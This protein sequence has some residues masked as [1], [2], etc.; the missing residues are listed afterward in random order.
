ML[1]P[2]ANPTKAQRG[3]QHPAGTMIGKIVLVGRNAMVIATGAT[4]T[5]GVAM[6]IAMVATATAVAAMEIAT[7]ATATAGAAMEIAIEATA[8]AGVAMEIAI[9][10]TATAGAAMVIATGATGIV[11]MELAVGWKNGMSVW[12]AGSVK[13]AS[14]RSSSRYST[15][16]RRCA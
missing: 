3:M 15:P 11:G 7:E 1:R 13:G 14:S 5:V 16:L 12:P 10:A 9:G 6:V 4:A 8:T 2:N